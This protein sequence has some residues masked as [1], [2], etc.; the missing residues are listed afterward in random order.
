[1]SKL[2][3][4]PLQV[5]GSIFKC[6]PRHHPGYIV[7]HAEEIDEDTSLQFETAFRKLEANPT[8]DSILIS[9][10]STGGCVYSALK[11]VDLMKNS[12]KHIITCCSGASMSAAA[13]IFSQGD[14]R[15]M[16]EYSTIMIHDAASVMEGRLN[17]VEVEAVELRRL[18][19]TCYE[20][21]SKNI[22]KNAKFFQNRM[23][24]KNTDTYLNAEQA[25]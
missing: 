5:D 9:I 12:E 13:L 15:F 24:K 1:M 19:E 14:T 11:I 25:R 18:T 23:S 22:G 17:D 3:N 21:M 4:V 8:L 6:I 7:I 16:S 20:M 2:I 10:H